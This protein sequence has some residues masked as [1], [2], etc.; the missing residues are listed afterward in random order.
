MAVSKKILLVDDNPLVLEMMGR[1]LNKE[2]FYCMKANSAGEAMKI[3]QQERPDIILSDYYMPDVD[4]FAFRQNLIAVPKYKDIPFMFLTSEDDNELMLNGINL[5]AVDYILKDTPL[6]VVVSKINNFLTT[7]REQHERTLKELSVAA[8]ALNL[9]SVPQ[10]L[11]VIKGFE[12]DFWHKPFQNYPGGDFIDFITIDA[13]H[14]FVILGDVMGKKWGAWYFSFGFL[15][16]IRAAV[17]ICIAEGNFS[18]KSIL[19]K[20]NAVVY[21]D[22]VVNDVLSSLSLLMIDTQEGAVTY[23]GAG[24]LP[25]LYYDALSKEL[26]QIGSSGMLLGLMPDGDFDEEV[27]KLNTGDRLFIFTDGIID[28][29]DTNGKKT[30]YNTFIN[31]IKP[32]LNEPFAAFKKSDFL[33][34][35]TVAHIDDCSLIHLQKTDR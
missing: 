25:L 3:L 32:Y 10:K 7:V 18:T 12:V 20:I 22:P 9:H 1:A 4:G 14:T 13:R 30:D 27:L 28:F 19:Q 24:D 8:M 17:R 2:G 5:E 33:Q 34:T 26:K 31:A 11:P 6:P 23:S 15:S 16:Y 21:H 35:K 29:E